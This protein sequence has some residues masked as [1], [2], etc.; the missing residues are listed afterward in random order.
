[1]SRSVSC[2]LYGYERAFAGMAKNWGGSPACLI[3]SQDGFTEGYAVAMTDE[4]ISML[5]VFEGYPEH[6]DRKKV[7]LQLHKFNNERNALMNEDVEGEFYRMIDTSDY[8]EPKVPYL[9]AVS[10][11]LFY[12]NHLKGEGEDAS[13]H[14]KVLVKR[15][16]DMAL[17]KEFSYSVNIV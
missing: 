8:Y 7:T 5:D 6:Y 10:R 2:T 9:E 17:T 4:E 14:I 16:Y 11:T 15:A 13:A 12:H 1:L 3:E